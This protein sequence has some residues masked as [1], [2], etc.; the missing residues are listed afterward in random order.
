MKNMC[1]VV[2]VVAVIY[3]Y[4]CR[5]ELDNFMEKYKPKNDSLMIIIMYESNVMKRLPSV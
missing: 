2:V 4:L 1:I 5:P 3:Y